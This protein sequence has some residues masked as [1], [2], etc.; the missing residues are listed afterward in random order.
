MAVY[1]S[2]KKNKTKN[3]SRLHTHKSL[4]CCD[5]AKLTLPLLT[6]C[7]F[8][9]NAIVKAPAESD[10]CPRRNFNYFPFI[11]HGKQKKNTITR[12]LDRSSV[13]PKEQTKLALIKQT[14]HARGSHKSK[15]GGAVMATKLFFH[16]CIF[17]GEYGRRT[18]SVEERNEN[19]RTVFHH[20]VFVC[21]RGRDKSR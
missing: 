17:R 4:F 9:F 10:W 14:P 6:S 8:T 20:F 18:D 3:V 5:G 16:I 15:G 7:S 19:V 2:H 12:R 21:D 13:V 1:H 11:Y